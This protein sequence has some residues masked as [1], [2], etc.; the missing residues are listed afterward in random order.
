LT[1]PASSRRSVAENHQQALAPGPFSK[2]KLGPTWQQFAIFAVAGDRNRVRLDVETALIACL[3]A[4]TGFVQNC[5]RRASRRTLKMAGFVVVVSITSPLGQ[6]QGEVQSLR[7]MVG[8][9]IVMGV[10]V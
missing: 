7:V 6:L 9:D 4:E 3:E 10:L 8:C 2:L 5:N 1:T